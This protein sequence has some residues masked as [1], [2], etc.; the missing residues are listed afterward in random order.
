MPTTT[1]QLPD[2]QNALTMAKPKPVT[3]QPQTPQLAMAQPQASSQAVTP[4]APLPSRIDLANQAV[5]TSAKA[6]DPYYQKSLRDAVSTAAGAGRLGSG[7]LRTS[8]GDLARNRALEL[9]TL[10]SNAINTATNSALDDAFRERDQ[11]LASE[12]LQLSGELGRGNLGVA[13]QQANT[14]QTSALGNLELAKTGQQ[15]QQSQF[16][17]SLDLQKTGQA[18]DIAAQQAQLELARSGQ[19]QQASQ[20]GQQLD[21]QKAQADI[22]AQF[23]AGTLSLAQRNQALQELQ[24]K[25]QH[26]LATSQLD[27]A[28]TGQEQQFGLDTQRV[29]LAKDQLA[30]QAAQFGASQEQ[31]MAIAKLADATANRSIDINSAQGHQQL[32]VQLAQILGTSTANI[33]AAFLNSVLQALG[34]TTGTPTGTTPKTTTPTS[35]TASNT[36]QTEVPTGP[37]QQQFVNNPYDSGL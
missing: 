20:F 16:G 35:T 13:Q 32:L 21:F 18:A 19:A 3:P 36:A 2:D 22:D 33:P 24:A 11:G 37:K 8:L 34:L 17:Q 15:I 29:Q 30:Q 31:Q 4:K 25:Q 27:L 28:R 9:D 26:D 6:T 12:Q 23:R 1:Q 14:S 7:M 10:R 5:E